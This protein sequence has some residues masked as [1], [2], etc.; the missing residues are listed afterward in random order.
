MVK[1]RADAHLTPGQRSDIVRPTIGITCDLD[2]GTGREARAPG[3]KCHVLYDDYVRAI[4]ESG[5]LPVLL[6]TGCR[7]ESRVAYAELLHGLVI[8]G[9]PADVDPAC[10]GEEPHAR[11]GPVNA[12]RTDFEIQMAR[13]A[14]KRDL[15]VFGICGGAQVL[16]VALG[17]ALYQDIPSQVAKAYKHVGAPDRAHTV[18]IVP[19]TRLAAIL[20]VQQMRV[21]SMHHQAV[22]V[23]GQGMVVSASSRDGVIEA[24]EISSLPFVMGV[25]WHPERLFVDDEASQR[26]FSAFV[27]VAAKAAKWR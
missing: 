23:P 20:D 13:L 3:R 10:Y 6:P 18:D 8:P 25:Q 22:K 24:V 27:Q 11:L 14:L 21:N 7:D 15:P 12:L 19:G 1:L 26:L 16:N 4:L 2:L 9:S 17:G 5:G